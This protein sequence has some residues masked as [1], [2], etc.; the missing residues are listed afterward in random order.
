MTKLEILK[1]CTMAGKHKFPLMIDTFT[2]LVKLL[3]HEGFDL[4]LVSYAWYHQLSK[5]KRVYV[6]GGNVDGS[7]RIG[8]VESAVMRGGI[9]VGYNI[10][11]GT[12]VIFR[13]LKQISSVVPD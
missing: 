4:K 1:I 2:S 10:R 11:F 12:G 6:R 8:T 3:N 9:I 5:G 13:K 7:H